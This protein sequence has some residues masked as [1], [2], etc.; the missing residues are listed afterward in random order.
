MPVN[1]AIAEELNNRLSN[2]IFKS[3]ADFVNF[4]NSG[5]IN[6]KNEEIT[7]I[8]AEVTSAFKDVKEKGG[9]LV[10]LSQSEV[11]LNEVL[12]ALLPW[13]ILVRA[14]REANDL[15]ASGAVSREATL[16]FSKKNAGFILKVS[17]NEDGE[18][19]K[20]GSE[21][22]FGKIEDV[23]PI[24]ERK[25]L[26]GERDGDTFFFYATDLADLDDSFIARIH[27][28]LPA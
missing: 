1:S 19:V 17:E 25:I 15:I 14:K 9:D 26:D 21:K 7:K 22:L 4:Y 2:T 23:A 8:V 13:E 3:A 5:L 27:E 18:L 11:L 12:A 20:V 10:F 16:A 28:G 24:F 6:K